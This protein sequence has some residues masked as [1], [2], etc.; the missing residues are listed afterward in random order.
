MTEHIYI[1]GEAKNIP[2][3]FKFIA[4]IK[5]YKYQVLES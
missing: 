1:S 4:I 2:K 5:K 3:L